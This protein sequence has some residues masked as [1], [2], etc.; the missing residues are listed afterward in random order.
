MNKFLLILTLTILLFGISG[1]IIAEEF[2]D[3]IKIYQGENT[4]NLSFD[5]NPLYVKDL[6]IIYPE[7]ATVTYN[8]SNQEWG[9]VNV[10]GGIGENFIISPNKI[11]TITT[12][13]EVNLNL[14]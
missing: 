11:Y 3:S 7:I 5:F 1:V 4:I 13:Q 8:E 12:N 2:K 14:R 9:Y 6:M 10:F